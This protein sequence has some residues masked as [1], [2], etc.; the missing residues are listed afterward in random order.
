MM[1]EKLIIGAIAGDMIGSRHNGKTAQSENFNLLTN[2]PDFTSDTVFTVAVMDA[3][4]NGKEYTQSLQ[5][6][7]LRYPDRGYGTALLRWMRQADPKPYHSWNNGAAL[8]VSPVGHA[9]R[10]LR[11]TMD[12][13]RRC[14]EVSHNH[15][16][17][18]KGAQ[19]IAVSVFLAKNGRTREE[20]RDFIESDFRYD[21]H[22]KI[23]DIR[24]RYYYDQSCE[25]SVPEA[26]I[27]FL[28]SRDFEHALRLA[29]SLGDTSGSLASITGGIAQAF[30]KEVPGY[31][32]QP[33]I[34]HLSPAMF[35]IVDKFSNTY[36]LSLFH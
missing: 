27:A 6:Y 15:P 9:C 31:L 16:D 8:R 34:Q 5:Q 17:G 30:Y 23:E 28:E 19:A 24:P 35:E 26:I 4:L 29:I 2:Q 1:P 7:G 22:R 14:A 21:L 25:S 10:T 13:A 18:I 3:L 20:I 36:P 32:A 33:V 11:E 12:E